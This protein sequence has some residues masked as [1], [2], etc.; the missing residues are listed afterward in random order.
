MIKTTKGGVIAAP[1]RLALWGDALAEA[2]LVARIPELHG[3]G[4]SGK[5]AALADAEQETNDHK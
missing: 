2:A 1:S 4:C 5:R 3:A